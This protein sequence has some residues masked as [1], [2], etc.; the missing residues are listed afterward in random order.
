[1]SIDETNVADQRALPAAL[2][3]LG[4][5]RQF[6]IWRY[7]PQRTVNDGRTF[8]AGKLR[9]AGYSDPQVEAL[10]IS[11]AKAVKAPINSRTLNHGNAHDPAHWLAAA[12]AFA[13]EAELNR[14]N[15][16]GSQPYGTGFVLT[17]AD[18]FGCLDL[19]GVLSDG[20]KSPVV[21]DVLAYFPGAAVEI[22]NSGHGLHVW[23]RHSGKLPAHKA[24]NTALGLELYET[25][26]YIALGKHD[27]HAPTGDANTDC[28]ATLGDVIA[29][30]FAPGDDT[31]GD[32]AQWTNEPHVEW[33]GYTDDDALIA[34]AKRSRSKSI[35]N[36]RATFAQ[37][38]QGDVDA[39]AKG[40]PTQSPGSD[41]DASSADLALANGLA[42][43]TGKDCERIERLMLASGLCRDK[44][45]QRADYRRSTILKAV[46]GCSSVYGMRGAGSAST[47]KP[48]AV[49]GHI[50]PSKP[51]ESD[52]AEMV[53][54]GHAEEHCCSVKTG[55]WYSR[56]PGKLWKFDNRAIRLRLLVHGYMK[57]FRMKKGSSIGGILKF[58]EP[59]L[60]D[61]GQWDTDPHLLGLPDDRVLDVRTGATREAYGDD[62][63]SRRISTQPEAGE[64]STWLRVLRQTHA[65]KPDAEAVIRYLQIFAGYALTGL[66]NT[67]K[68]L[69]LVGPPGGGK[70]TFVNTLAAVWGTADNEGYATS[71]PSD[72]LLDGRAQHAQWLTLFDGPRLAF[73]GESNNDSAGQKGRTWRV[74]D[75]KTLTAFDTISANRMRQDS[76][77]FRPTAKLIIGANNIPDMGRFDP[78][79]KRRM[80][81]VRC[82]N[83]IPDHLA[84]IGLEDKLRAEYGRI[85]T[86]A[87]EG[88]A[89]YCRNGLPTMPGSM[90]AAR[91][92]YLEAQDTFGEFLRSRYVDAP[93][94][95]VPGDNLRNEHTLW[96]Q[97]NS[98]GIPWSDRA[99]KQEM[100]NRGYRIYRKRVGADQYRGFL[101]LM[102]KNRIN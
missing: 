93:G 89:E 62:R 37:L 88:A 21:D 44:L 68:F 75:L 28:T 38:W 74:G 90:T 73:V 27:E 34:K 23:F 66:T 14:D 4:D 15:G 41:Y 36:E 47:V 87:I 39:L 65:G 1:M 84:D 42:F 13:R 49:T 91:D 6:V 29:R 70:G 59:E 48:G 46:A 101:G 102:L 96:L 52:A 43:W 81:L 31:G 72:A 11:D 77:T 55:R 92:D 67:H 22:S 16:D 63:I 2:A 10:P 83:P 19:D 71:V 9:K 53:K 18:P 80:A 95:F 25:A 3:G 45:E 51:G 56:V 57:E 64:P 79:L 94:Q 61:R 40:Y 54:A 86:W 58:L 26:R 32:S 12:E 78:A 24:K 17:Q 30:W 69:F 85:L 20:Q 100:A 7:E 97:Q 8:E 82:D 99:R 35:F 50:E 33:N 98:D 5:F 60:A 76:Y